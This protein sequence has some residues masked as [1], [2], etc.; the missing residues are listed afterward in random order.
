MGET[1]PIWGLFV[2]ER[3]ADGSGGVVVE[4]DRAGGRFR[5]TGTATTTINSLPDGA[6]ARLTTW[7]IDRHLEGVELPLI[8]SDIV[9]QAKSL[10]PLMVS[11]RVDRL[12][13]YFS[14][15]SEH[16]GARIDYAFGEGAYLEMKAWS[17]SVVDEELS[18]L[19]GIL[20][21]AG[22][23]E[24]DRFMGGGHVTVLV[25]GYERLDALAQR[26]GRS[27]QGF[28]AMWFDTSMDPAFIEGLTAGIKDAGYRPLR[29][30]RK[31]HNN[32]IDDEMIA[33]IRRSRFLVADFTQTDASGARG[34]V[35][36]EAGFAH[37]LGIPV[38]L[39]CREDA[40]QR[41]HF[42]T[43]QYN[44]LLW[45]DPADLRAKLAKRISATIGDGP[46]RSAS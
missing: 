30:D 12:L 35:Y 5:I 3:V 36:Y 27:A 17:E 13:R 34:G 45:S 41:V 23:L 20:Q 39:T 38:I 8:T 31:P 46:E 10:R 28:V 37:G 15:Q 11:S 44:H 14:D 16:V 9:E 7:L 40:I 1:C 32:R 21:E 18:F 2:R 19:L 4:S 26:S 43:R 42:D 6:K 22:Y 24:I 25:P 29:I 33:E